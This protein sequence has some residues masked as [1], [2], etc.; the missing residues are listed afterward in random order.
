MLRTP[1]SDIKITY[2]GGIDDARELGRS[3]GIYMSF[4]FTAKNSGLGT[5]DRI[6]AKASI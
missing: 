2:S 4:L 3:P 5:E 1:A 6:D